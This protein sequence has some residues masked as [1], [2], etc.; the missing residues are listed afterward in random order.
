[1][2]GFNSFVDACR[3]TKKIV[4]HSFLLKQKA[5]G[6]CHDQLCHL[7]HRREGKKLARP[8]CQVGTSFQ[9]QQ[10]EVGKSTEMCLPN[11]IDLRIELGLSD[12]ASR[13]R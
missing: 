5:P 4:C 7:S 10:R 12:E 1:M 6:R 13:R 9:S 2:K 3:L 8:A 11:L